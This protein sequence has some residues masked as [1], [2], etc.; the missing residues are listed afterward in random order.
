MFSLSLAGRRSATFATFLVA[1]I[2][3]LSLF[4]SVTMQNLVLEASEPSD[5]FFACA[6]CEEIYEDRDNQ[7][8]MLEDFAS[9]EHKWIEMNDPG[10]FDSLGVR[11]KCLLV[12][13][14]V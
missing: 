2:L 7:I 13:L 1:V 9:P 6:D 12:T 11:S 8:I 14:H 5:D 4:P 3:G 10:K